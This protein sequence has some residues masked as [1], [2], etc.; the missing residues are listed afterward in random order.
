MFALADDIV[1]AD[2]REDR[3][4][5]GPDSLSEAPSLILNPAWDSSS[6][7]SRTASTDGAG[8]F[9]VMSDRGSAYDG[10]LVSSQKKQ[11]ENALHGRSY[12]D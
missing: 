10:Q 4:C 3:A 2:C 8:Y 12:I 5:L 11:I 9:V 6:E 1:G 7:S